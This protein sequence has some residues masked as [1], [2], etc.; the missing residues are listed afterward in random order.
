MHP[1]P[2]LGIISVVSDQGLGSESEMQQQINALR[3]QVAINGAIIDALRTRSD[4][5]SQRA[6]DSE[7]RED[8]ARNRADAS[9]ARADK[10]RLRIDDLETHVDIDREMILELQDA[11]VLHAEQVQHR[12]EALKTSRKIGAA[13]G[14]VMAKAVVTEEDAFLI[15]RKASQNRNRKLRDLAD[16]LALAGDTSGLLRT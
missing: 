3:D 5:S 12:Q 11:G 15:L 4:V 1:R 2:L 16:E 13:I 9:E 8:L 10:D 7:A 14:L 6:D